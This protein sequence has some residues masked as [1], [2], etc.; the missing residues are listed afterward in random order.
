ME[1][2]EG[3]DVGGGVPPVVDMGAVGVMADFLYEL[4]RD[5]F[6]RRGASRWLWL[7]DCYVLLSGALRQAQP[8]EWFEAEGVVETMRALA[9]FLEELEARRV[10]LE[11]GAG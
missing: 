10:E 7:F 3:C 6:E 8:L 9:R 11:G 1:T 2:K 5:G 4:I